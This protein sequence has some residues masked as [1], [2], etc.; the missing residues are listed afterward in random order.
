MTEERFMELVDLV[1]NSH[2]YA[3]PRI[4]FQSS[5]ESGIADWER[6]CFLARFLMHPALDRK[7]EAIE[8]F[9]EALEESTGIEMDQNTKDKK[10]WLLRD[11]SV[12]ESHRGDNEKALDYILQSINI[13]NSSSCNYEYVIRGELVL[14]KLSILCALGREDEADAEADRL[15]EEHADSKSTNDSYIYFCYRFKA[16]QAA[17]RN[18]LAEA[19]DFLLKSLDFT[20]QHNE[21][22]EESRAA[23]C[24]FEIENVA[25]EEAMNKMIRCLPGEHTQIVWWDMPGEP[26]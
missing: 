4:L 17:S 21:Y 16:E 8:L 14:Q 13:A 1:R 9:Q 15:I 24:K 6:K 22:V 3:P 11:L 25:C 23:L 10:A 26:Y 5:K 18:D 19:R 20:K 2:P 7:D 12:L